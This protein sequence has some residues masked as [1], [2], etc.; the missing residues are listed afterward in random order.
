VELAVWSNSIDEE[1]KTKMKRWRRRR[2]GTW[3]N[4][5]LVRN[6]KMKKKREKWRKEE[7]ILQIVTF[8]KHKVIF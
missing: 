7:E 5:P 4:G 3:Q 1:V 8:H 2:R 6:L